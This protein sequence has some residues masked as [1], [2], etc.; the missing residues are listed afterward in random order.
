[1]RV[2]LDTNV[3][4]DLLVSRVP[5]VKEAKAIWEATQHARL[6]SFIPASALTDTFYI[7]RRLVGRDVARNAVRQCLDVLT[8]LS[9]DGALLEQA[10][11]LP[12]DDYEDA[13]QAACVL[14]YRLDA[15]VTRDA[16]GFS[17]A[18][19]YVLTP[20]ALVARLPRGEDA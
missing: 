1:M 3:V 6:E 19:I 8:I 14:H 11:A 4:I 9:V 2:L 20:E 16:A 15:I 17:N 13:L 5:W 18:G 10:Y 12:Y 7:V